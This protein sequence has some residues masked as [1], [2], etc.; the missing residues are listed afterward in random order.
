M[1]NVALPS[2]LAAVQYI[3]NADYTELSESSDFGECCTPSDTRTGDLHHTT[4][5]KEHFCVTEQVCEQELTAELSETPV[6]L[7]VV[8][9]LFATLTTTGS[10]LLSPITTTLTSL[11]LNNAVPISEPPLFLLNSVFLN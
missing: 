6:I 10:S 4:N 3:C 2:A 1:V 7:P 9:Q 5:L 8:P 11:T